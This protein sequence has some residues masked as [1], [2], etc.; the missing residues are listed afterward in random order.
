MNGIEVHKWKDRVEELEQELEA[1]ITAREA[2]RKELNEQLERYRECL[3]DQCYL[4]HCN[5]PEDG[6]TKEFESEGEE[7]I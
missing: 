2:E 4:C 3:K 7:C 6:C 1:E 5:D